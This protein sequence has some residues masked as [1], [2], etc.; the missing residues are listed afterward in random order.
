[1]R[2]GNDHVLAL[3]QVL[4]L[5][6]RLFFR[7]DGA[8]RRRELGA[9]LGELGLDDR[10]DARARAQDVEIIGD[11]GGELVELF[12]DLVAAERGEALQ[13]QIEDRLRLLG[14]EASRAG[15]RD[16]VP[17]IVDQQHHVDH[18][19]GRPVA[20]HQ[21]LSRLPGVAR[22]ADELDHLVDIGDGDGEADQHVGAV[23]R[24][25]EQELGAPRH[26]LFAEGDE[27]LQHVAQV[28]RQRPAA[29]E[30]DHVAAKRGLQRRETVELVQHHLALGVAL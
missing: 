27:G 3:D 20:R 24:L 26:H 22:G 13:P 18:V 25:V 21:R 7:N 30:R 19:L 15:L 9:H 5:D 29:V 28:H 14:R 11:L 6:L 16:G 12:L 17:R 2:D 23:T 1:M 8:A 10:L 4:V